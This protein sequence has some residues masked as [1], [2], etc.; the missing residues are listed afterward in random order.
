MILCH[1][2][3]N[4]VGGSRAQ[5]LLHSRNK[6]LSICQDFNLTVGGGRRAVLTS[7]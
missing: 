2:V 1:N 4:A 5:T 3:A 6:I 7:L